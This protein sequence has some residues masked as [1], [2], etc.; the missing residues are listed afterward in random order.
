MTALPRPAVCELLPWDS[1]F[2]RCRIGR[3][4]GSRLNE[5]QAAAIEEWSRN[6]R[7]DGLYFL[8]D[9]RCAETIRTAENHGFRLVDIRMTLE[10]NTVKERLFTATGTPT[11]VAIHPAR[12]QD[13]PSLQAIARAAHTDTRF[14]S[15]PHIPRERAED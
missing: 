6:E 5:S 9:A 15:D 10:R 11:G 12:P 1:E 14:F 2:F 4:S 7:L 3:V 8:A 13:L